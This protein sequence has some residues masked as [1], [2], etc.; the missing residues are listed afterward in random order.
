MRRSFRP[1]LSAVGLWVLVVG[2]ELGSV[3]VEGVG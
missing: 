3:M 1:L 2:C